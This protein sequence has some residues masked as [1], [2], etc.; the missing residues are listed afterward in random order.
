MFYKVSN[1]GTWIKYVCDFGDDT[2]KT[3]IEIYR[4]T[5]FGLETLVK[6]SS[7]SSYTY[8]APDGLKIVTTRSNKSVKITPPSGKALRYIN[9]YNNHGS[10][11]TTLNTDEV[12]TS[13]AGVYGDVMVLGYA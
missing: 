12:L 3:T 10:D 1:G 2:T 11:V 4:V 8:T 13:S 6:T 7:T 5:S 9:F